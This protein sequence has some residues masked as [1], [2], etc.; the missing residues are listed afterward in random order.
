MEGIKDHNDWWVSLSV[1]GFSS[2]L[3]PEVYDIFNKYKIMLLLED[4]NTSQTNQ[5]FDQ[6][7]EKEDKHN[8]RS[9]LDKQGCVAKDVND[10]WKLI[11]VCIIALKNSSKQA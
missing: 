1:D 5:T 10:Q 9:L 6:Q 2:H 7:K 4:D 8:I 11:A 3:I